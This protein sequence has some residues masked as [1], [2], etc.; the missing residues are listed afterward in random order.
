[1]QGIKIFS[2]AKDRSLSGSDQQF[3]GSACVEFNDRKGALEPNA[4]SL[5]CH[6]FRGAFCLSKTALGQ[7]PVR[8]WRWGID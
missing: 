4:P 8:E 1:M 6:L 2:G 5:L 7:S 3:H